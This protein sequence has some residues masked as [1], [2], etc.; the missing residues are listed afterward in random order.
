MRSF[1]QSSSESDRLA[2]PILL[3]LLTVLV[4]SVGTV[5][6]MRE[7]VRNERL[8]T[9]QRLTEA[10]Q[11]HLQSASQAVEDRWIAQLEKLSEQVGKQTPAQAFADGISN[12]IADSLLVRDDQGQIVYPNMATTTTEEMPE[13]VPAWENAERLE[14]IGQWHKAAEAY[15]RIAED[16]YGPD[17]ASA[18]QAQVRSLLKGDKRIEAI[19]VLQKLR[20]QDGLHDAQG[21]SFAAAAELR[22][23]EVL[24]RDTKAWNEV[25]NSLQRRLGDYQ[26]NTLLAPQRRFL[27]NALQE[28]ASEPL[29]WP[30]QPAEELAARAISIY[31]P[32][33]ATPRL[34]PTPLAG[35]WSC[36]SQDGSVVGLYRAESLPEQILKLTN[37]LALPK[38]VSFV[39]SGPQESSEAILDTS[40]GKSLPGW[41]L[42][43]IADGNPFD[44]TS[45]QRKAVHA[46]IALL[47]VAATCV[48][49]WL[50]ASTLQRRMRLAQLKNDLVATVSHELKTPLASIRLLV[51]TLLE[52]ENGE[53]RQS[54]KNNVR[55]YLKL[56]SHENARLTRLIDN[57]LTFS[58][59]ERDKQRFDYQVIDVCEVIQQAAAIFCERWDDECLH[60]VEGTEALV[61]G[62]KDALV[63]AVV[64]LLENARKY[65]DENREIHLT[66]ATLGD[67]VTIA[68]R[69]NGIGMSPGATRHVFDRFYQVDQRV[70]RSEGGCGL[71]LSIV[72]AIM[73]SH[74]GDAKVKSQP[75]AGS[76]FTLY[77]PKFH[78]DTAKQA[79]PVHVVTVPA[80]DNR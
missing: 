48:L 16:V 9:G 57:F 32:S 66:S 59:L 39:V 24:D 63:T 10:Y 53:P 11:A 70:A 60:V 40:L 15:A 42:G 50:L 34:H 62:D 68:V 37:D 64:N 75:G 73:Q 41:R 5:W 38:G 45:K 71:G 44:E 22:L 27:M 25:A 78:G 72:A 3:L 35:M 47:V 23:L 29:N 36:A 77:L 79:A 19:E 4:P 13:K 12:G 49:G 43:L 76:T 58:R 65:S 56:I 33:F 46:W 1:W 21:R 51:D 8:A 31:E 54:S 6:M 26:Q 18:W 20:G 30:T 7:A 52:S 17:V 2:W 28:L 69:D 14:F 67:Q 74:G 55:E 61:L 80:E